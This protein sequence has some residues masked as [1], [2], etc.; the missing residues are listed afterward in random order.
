MNKK[1]STTKWF[2]ISLIPI[3]NLYFLWK[4]AENVSGHG[5]GVSN[6]YEIIEH[7]KEKEPTEKW[8]IIFIIPFVLS[9]FAT[10]FSYSMMGGAGSSVAP[11]QAGSIGAVFGIFTVLA[12]V[13]GIYLL[14]KA[15]EIVSGHEKVY[16]EYEVIRHKGKKESTFKW[17]LF[18]IIPILNIY[19]S[20][21]VAEMVS[22]HELKK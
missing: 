20:W 7:L 3:I 6:Q 11:A 10:A 14:W 5:K 13:V 12:V 2:V 18:G 1:E 19:F 16:K 21:K 9:L 22:G 8:F 4:L 17:F 15:A